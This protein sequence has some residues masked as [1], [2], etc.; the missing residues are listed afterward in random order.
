MSTLAGVFLVLG[1]LGILWLVQPTDR[2][3]TSRRD[4]AITTERPLR[5]SELL[6]PAAGLVICLLIVALSMVHDTEQFKQL[7]GASKQL[8]A[9]SRQSEAFNL[10]ITYDGGQGEKVYQ[11]KS[12]GSLGFCVL[13][14]RAGKAVGQNPFLRAEAKQGAQFVQVY[15]F[16]NN[17]GKQAILIIDDLFVLLYEDREYGVSLSATMALEGDGRKT[18][19]MLQL[20]PG[21]KDA[22]YLVFEVPESMDLTK[23]QI[24]FSDNILFGTAKLVPVLAYPKAQ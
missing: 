12:A 24:R 11:G 9:T 19:S 10:T 14:V 23:A 21:L 16:V 7:I 5:I 20:N 1:V 4:G 6:V 15:A 3:G 8:L 2:R 18:L 17:V 22:G 13:E